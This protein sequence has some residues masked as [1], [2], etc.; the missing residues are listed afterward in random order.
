M[1]GAIVM[2]YIAFGVAL[3]SGIL[4]AYKP[5]WWSKPEKVKARPFYSMFLLERKDFVRRQLWTLRCFVV[6]HLLV[7]CACIAVG[8]WGASGI[9]MFFFFLPI[10]H[11][12][13]VI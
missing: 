7:T 13:S 2:L 6:L 3:L 8:A 10:R 5:V 12:L 4:A 11:S 1:L 9:S